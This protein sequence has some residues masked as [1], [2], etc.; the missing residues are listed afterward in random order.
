[1]DT[2]RGSSP[3]RAVRTAAKDDTLSHPM[4][5]LAVLA[6]AAL[7][8]GCAAR[9]SPAPATA[10]SAADAGLAPPDDATQPPPR[11]DDATMLPRPY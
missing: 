1:M 4:L 9:P 2:L 6:G 11:T 7:L 8:C 10:A 3:D 5:R